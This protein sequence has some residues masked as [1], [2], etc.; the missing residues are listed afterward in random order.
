MIDAGR[1][2]ESGPSAVNPGLDISRGLIQEEA[3]AMEKPWIVQT[4]NDGGT[5]T[6]HHN[7]ATGPTEE[8]IGLGQ[9]GEHWIPL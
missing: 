4:S 1:V 7:Q 8:E 5:L 3:M 2:S 6:R 9:R